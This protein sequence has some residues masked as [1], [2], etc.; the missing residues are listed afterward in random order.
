M[1]FVYYRGKVPS[2]RTRPRK[3]CGQF[4]CTLS[5]TQQQSKSYVQIQKKFYNNMQ[6][7]RG[8]ETYLWWVESSLKQMSFVWITKEGVK[9]EFRDQWVQRSRG[10][11]RWTEMQE[12]AGGKCGGDLRD[13]EKA[14]IFER[15]IVRRKSS[16]LL[17]DGWRSRENQL[18]WFLFLELFFF[19]RETE[20]N[21]HGGQ[22]LQR[23]AYISGNEHLKG[24]YLAY[25]IVTC[26]RNKYSISF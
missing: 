24:H 19:W 13:L 22:F 21:A 18:S 4:T 2:S 8:N 17:L 23:S 12:R 6:K 7:C 5:D 3:S 20:M 25:T 26:K 10:T 11:V 16:A 1:C 9:L 14:R 15:T